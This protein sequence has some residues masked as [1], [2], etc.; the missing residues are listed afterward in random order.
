MSCDGPPTVSFSLPVRQR[1]A[2]GT[3]SG[4]MRSPSGK[5]WVELGS[6]LA[7][8]HPFADSGVPAYAMFVFR[9]YR[10]PY[11]PWARLA[12]RLGP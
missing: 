9:N 3:V 1:G 11:W 7:E 4:H 2:R 8:Y 6:I 10:N 12:E 5:R